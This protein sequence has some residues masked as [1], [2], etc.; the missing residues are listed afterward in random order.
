MEIRVVFENTTKYFKLTL[1]Y[2]NLR[3]IIFP[4]YFE[5]N[6]DLNS[7]YVSIN[8]FQALKDHVRNVTLGR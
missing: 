8:I 1:Q 2:F 7:F 4:K 3:F 5:I 6:I